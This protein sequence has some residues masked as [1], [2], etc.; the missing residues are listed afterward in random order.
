MMHLLRNGSALDCG[1]SSTVHAL[2]VPCTCARADLRSQICLCRD[3]LDEELQELD[4][5]MGVVTINPRYSPRMIKEKAFRTPMEGLNTIV[6]AALP[7]NPFA[8]VVQGWGSC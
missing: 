7:Q 4:N 5:V 2:V 6:R 1:V 8:Q 3:K